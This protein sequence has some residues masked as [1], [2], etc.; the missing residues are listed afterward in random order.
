MKLRE[1]IVY[2]ILLSLLLLAI[3]ILPFNNSM[4]NLK[5]DDYNIEKS[6]LS[7]N[8]LEYV[9]HLHESGDPTFAKRPLTTKL[10]LAVSENSNFTVAESFVL[11]QWLL[12]V[13][14]GIALGLLSNQWLQ[15]R[16]KTRANLLMFYLSF[17][18]V[19]LFFEP[20]YSY[21][22]PLQYFFIF[23]AMLFFI[24]NKLLLFILSFSLACVARESS[25]FLLPGLFFI[26]HPSF[27]IQLTT[28]WKTLLSITIIIGLYFIFRVYQSQALGLNSNAEKQD[29]L[30]RF[31][32]LKTNF[33]GFAPIQNTIMSMLV[34][35]LPWTYLLWWNYK[36]QT[37]VFM[38]YRSA[39]VAFGIAMLINTPIVL[40]L[41]NAREVRLFFLPFF[42]L[43]PIVG[44]FLNKDFLQYFTKEAL[45]QC[46]RN[47]KHLFIL[48]VL[49]VLNF[50]FTMLTFRF[51]YTT[52]KANFFNEYLFLMVNLVLLHWFLSRKHQPTRHN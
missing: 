16:N 34:V 21:D 35:M 31:V 43:L 20:I 49:T 4:I 30:A 38:K 23:M 41:T 5:T 26:K 29:F 11:T 25:L 50:V 3:H 9:V 46:I 45:L 13:L 33:G 18:V 7:S 51:E 8:Y 15:N 40:L 10:I 19:F 2:S 47:K 28:Q 12:L 52:Q 22:E 14:C 44:A 17:S 37:E 32:A 48:L 27:K 36:N 39:I 1:I 42:F 6:W 24:Q